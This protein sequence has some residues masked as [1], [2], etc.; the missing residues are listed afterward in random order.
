MA[1][2]RL[3]KLVAT[4]NDLG[5][6]SITCDDGEGHL[7]RSSSVPCVTMS[8]RSQS[9][10]RA[11]IDHDQQTLDLSTTTTTKTSRSAN[12]M[13]LNH[14]VIARLKQLKARLVENERLLDDY[15]QRLFYIFAGFKSLKAN[16]KYMRAI[17]GDT[18]VE[19]FKARLKICRTS[20][21]EHLNTPDSLGHVVLNIFSG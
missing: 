9:G 2:A 11:C 4:L 17:F 21:N 20:S 15:K 14:H 19:Q 13:L 12:K 16:P 6:T 1:N 8:R 3:A 10:S 7:R 18:L 5:L